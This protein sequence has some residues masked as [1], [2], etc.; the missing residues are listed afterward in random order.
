MNILKKISSFDFRTY[1][2]NNLIYS[3]LSKW[4]KI[5]EKNIL[6]T[7]GADGGLLRI[8]NVF[9]DKND[10]VLTLELRLRRS[11]QYIVKCLRQ[12]CSFQT[13]LT[14]K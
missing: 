4:L 6:I 14:N 1:P 9:A 10:V 2:D 7:E 8:F 3:R 5:K 12:V 13:K 11:I